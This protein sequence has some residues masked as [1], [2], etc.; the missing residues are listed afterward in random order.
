MQTP[1]QVSHDTIAILIAILGLP[2]IAFVIW[3]L[4]KRDEW[5]K[6]LIAD[7]KIRHKMTGDKRAAGSIEED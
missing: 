7:Y 1:G 4:A 5:I 2:N 6:W 3:Y